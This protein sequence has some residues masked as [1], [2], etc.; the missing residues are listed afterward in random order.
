MKAAPQGFYEFFSLTCA[1][2]KEKIEKTESLHYCRKINEAAEIFQL[3]VIL[4]AD[5]IA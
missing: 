5:T 2:N 3:Q 1:I 4:K